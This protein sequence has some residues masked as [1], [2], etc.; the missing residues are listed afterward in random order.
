MKNRKTT[1]GT[2]NKYHNVDKWDINA[3]LRVLLQ[4]RDINAY[5]VY[6]IVKS[7]FK[8]RLAMAQ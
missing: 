1:N 8:K 7:N 5:C 6:M 4:K 2:G 3:I